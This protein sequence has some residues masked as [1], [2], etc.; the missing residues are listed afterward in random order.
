LVSANLSYDG[1]CLCKLKV[2]IQGT[3]VEIENTLIDTGFITVSGYGLKLP[4]EY[5]HYAQNYG[6]GEVGMADGRRVIGISI[7]RIIITEFEDQP[8]VNTVTI[9]T[10][11]LGGR[12]PVIGMRFL[13]RCIM[14]LD[15]IKRNAI[16]QIP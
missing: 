4:L 9:P 1:K 8:L 6:I 14:N 16:V 5:L 3:K 11:I 13:Q 10:I 2:I 7:P 12:T 15:G